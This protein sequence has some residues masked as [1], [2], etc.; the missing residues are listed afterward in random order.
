MGADG[1]ACVEVDG[2]G[3]GGAAEEQAEC[4]GKNV[5]FHGHSFSM[6]GDNAGMTRQYH[7]RPRIRV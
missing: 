4:C 6:S 3:L 5:S 7:F 1:V 2:S